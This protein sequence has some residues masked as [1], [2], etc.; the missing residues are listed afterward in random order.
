MAAKIKLVEDVADIVPA[1]KVPDFE[2]APSGEPVSDEER[3]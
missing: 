3:G 2:P 1:P